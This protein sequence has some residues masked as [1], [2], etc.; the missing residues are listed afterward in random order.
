MQGEI[1]TYTPELGMTETDETVTIHFRSLTERDKRKVSDLIIAETGGD[2]KRMAE[3]NDWKET[4]IRGH[5]QKV[6]GY[7]YRGRTITGVDDF[8]EYADVLLFNEV[9]NH[10]Y[11]SSVLTEEIR[12]KLGERSDS[13]QPE[14]HRSTGIAENAKPKGSTSYEIVAPSAQAQTSST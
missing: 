7:K 6:T 8:L 5:L 2:P 13:T 1:E 10:I 12:K 4:L 3:K 14:T 9:A 11:A